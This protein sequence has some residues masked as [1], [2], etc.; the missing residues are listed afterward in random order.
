MDAFKD[1][2]SRKLEEVDDLPTLP[3]AATALDKALADPATDARDIAEILATDPS[4]ASKVLRLANSAYYGGAAG[5]LTS[6]PQA[7][8]RIGFREIGRVFT[9]VAVIQTF[10]DIGHDLNHV[11]FWKHCLTTAITTRIIRKNGHQGD[12]FGEDDAY[13]AGLLHDI[14]VL[15]LDQYFPK[16]LGQVWQIAD[17]KDCPHDAAERIILKMDHGEIGAQLLEAWKLPEAVIEAV[18]CHH[19]PDRARPEHRALARAVYLAEA[20]C[21]HMGIGDGGDGA[22]AE[23]EFGIWE[24]L[25]LQPEQ[26]SE[27]VAEITEEANKSEALVNLAGE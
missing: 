16:I 17:E 12:A 25:G 23:F 7:V 6:I 18:T 14:G 11:R 8:A 9:T 2:L 4:L 22:V 3:T 10:E 15:V 20:I 27:I 19:E 1:K 13:I 24:E 21:T 5:T 26:F